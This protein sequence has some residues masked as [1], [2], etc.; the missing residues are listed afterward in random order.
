MA[1]ER[2]LITGGA[3]YLGSVM[4]GWFLGRGHKVR[5][6]DSLIHS[7]ASPLR[8]AGDPNF[9]FS[10]GDVRDKDLM[11]KLVRENDV[12]FP[13][14]ALVGMP[15]CERNPDDAKSTNY[16]AVVMLNKIRSKNQR[17]IYPTTNS[18]YGAK[19]GDVFCTE[20]TPLEPISLYGQ[21]KSDAEKA[22][23][24]A[25]E[26]VTF[27]LA[28]VFGVS[29]RH[30]LD[31]L[32]NDFVFKAM[33]D[34]KLVLYE[35]HFK[36]NF[37]GTKDVAKA[38]GFAIDRFDFMKNKPYNLGLEDANLSKME[39]A[40]R[41]KQYIPELGI[42]IGEGEDPDKR[43]Y[44]VSNKR[45]LSTGFRTEMTLGEGIQEL[46]RFYSVLLSDNRLLNDKSL[47]NV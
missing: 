32:V 6:V 11:K 43:N 18:G 42:T 29:P 47:R 19:S 7:Q 5:V 25:G 15:I 16:D 3:G 38:F 4:T 33:K 13:L 10:R 20:E 30:R 17:L 9:Y 26:V 34:K 28:T 27:R 22:L 14:A 24:D 39:L 8:F 44:I 41:I 23:L 46:M 35:P 45:I 40:L 21:T 2:I 36:R 31:L 12:L 37:V 1:K